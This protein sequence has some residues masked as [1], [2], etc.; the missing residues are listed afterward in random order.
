MTI[1]ELA[2][3]TGV[4]PS[5]IRYYESVGVLPPP[6]RC[7]GAR[8]YD[9]SAADTIR[10]VLIAQRLGLSLAEIRALAAGEHSLAAVADAH[11]RA[12]DAAI[13]RARVVRALLRHAA[14][15]AAMPA[16]RYERML[17]RVDA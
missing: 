15:V 12:L 9:R 5:R 17:A 1:G 8:S 13:R 4:R 11:V 6:S 10:D 3:Q 2:R 16:E 14:R 7:S